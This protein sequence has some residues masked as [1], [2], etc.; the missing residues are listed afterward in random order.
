MK[1]QVRMA[2]VL[3]AGTMLLASCGSSD[4]KGYKQTDDGLYYRFEQ[5]DK[6]AQQ[7]QE[8]DVLVGVV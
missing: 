3:V 6:N 5:Q 1:K 8:G 7:V 4:M 2:T